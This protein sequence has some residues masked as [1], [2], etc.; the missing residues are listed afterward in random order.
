MGH[1]GDCKRLVN[2]QVDSYTTSHDEVDES[3]EASAGQCGGQGWRVGGLTAPLQL[4][5]I[6]TRLMECRRFLSL[7]LVCCQCVLRQAR[8]KGGMCAGGHLQYKG[9][10]RTNTQIFVL[11][12]IVRCDSGE[13]GRFWGEGTFLPTFCASS[14]GRGDISRAV[15]ALE[16][17]FFLMV[18]HTVKTLLKF[19]RP[20]LDMT[21][22]LTAGAFG[23]GWVAT[24]RCRHCRCRRRW[25]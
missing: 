4:S 9:E 6:E 13:G 10:E 12:F 8:E 5:S 22:C 3:L 2:F 19:A 17:H 15:L 20:K 1:G 21:G 14:R 25:W 7:L 18:E 16:R 11:F 23:Y 24:G